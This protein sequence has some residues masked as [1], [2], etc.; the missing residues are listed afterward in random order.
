MT[1][2]KQIAI[3]LLAGSTVVVGTFSAQFT[4]IAAQDRLAVKA[5]HDNHQALRYAT[6]VTADGGTTTRDLLQESADTCTAARRAFR[7][8]REQQVATGSPTITELKALRSAAATE[9]NAYGTLSASVRA[10][11]TLYEGADQAYECESLK[12]N[13]PADGGSP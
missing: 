12:S 3:A 6:A 10:A 1:T 4:G 13:C 8:A 2:R 9:C 11:K 5:T 7:F